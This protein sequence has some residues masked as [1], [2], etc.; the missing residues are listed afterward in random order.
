MQSLRSLVLN[1]VSEL[2]KGINK[3][4]VES[5]TDKRQVSNALVALSSQI[6]ETKRE[7]NARIDSVQTSLG[8]QLQELLDY[9]HR[10]DAKKGEEQ[11][12]QEEL[13]RRTA[14]ERKRSQGGRGGRGNQWFN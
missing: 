9:V 8:T 4:R 1:N 2:T 3:M 11:R 10:G 14:E 13:R 5:Q 12:K 7:L 6:T